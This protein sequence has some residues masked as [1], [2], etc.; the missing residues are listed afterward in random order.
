MKHVVDKLRELERRIAGEKGEF[1]L[2]ALVLRENSPDRWD[3]VVA[4]PWIERNTMNALRY[5]ARRLGETLK[6]TEMLQLSRIAPLKA[7]YP[8]LEGLLRLLSTAGSSIEIKDTDVSGLK[9]KHAY[10]IT[11]RR[12]TSTGRKANGDRAGSAKPSGAGR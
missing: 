10:V 6:P 2:F 5:L 7:G 1:S 3:L 11:S 12:L 8:V 4:A 9:I